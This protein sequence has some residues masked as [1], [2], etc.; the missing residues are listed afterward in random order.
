MLGRNTMNEFTNVFEITTAYGNT[1]VT[2]QFLEVAVLFFL[3]SVAVLISVFK[4]YIR[5]TDEMDL[6]KLL[7]FWLLIFGLFLI[8][9]PSEYREAYQLIDVYR[10]GKC[11]IT[12]GIVHVAH[13]QPFGGHSPG[14]II[15]IGDKKFTLNYYSATFGYNQ[16]ISHGGALG[17]G[18]YAR[19]H[20]Y[21]CVI[22]KVEVK[23]QL[24]SLPYYPW[25]DDS[26]S[27]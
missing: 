14:D 3:I 27:R 12:E 13:Y 16:T 23:G 19:L 11:E 22:L 7:L 20:H 17:E 5:F 21:N 6:L 9:F 1:L 8:I 10:N 25:P 2:T 26:K 4:G 24:G 15:F 18:V